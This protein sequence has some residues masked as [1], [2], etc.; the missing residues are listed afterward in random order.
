MK[1]F[2][3][4]IT[5]RGRPRSP[6][7]HQPM[8]RHRERGRP[9]PHSAPL[10]SLAERSHRGHPREWPQ[11]PIFP[12]DDRP[13]SPPVLKPPQPDATVSSS[14]SVNRP[15]SSRGLATPAASL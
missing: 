1:Q 11:P 12:F 13:P 15:F 3:N 4:V 8:P 10:T 2:T 6:V 14:N 5:F 7:R 9:H